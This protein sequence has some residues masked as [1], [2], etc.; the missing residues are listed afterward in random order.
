MLKEYKVPI[1]FVE[2]DEQI[3]KKGTITDEVTFFAKFLKER[4]KPQL[5]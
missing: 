3:S 4:G 1:D 2:C 5:H